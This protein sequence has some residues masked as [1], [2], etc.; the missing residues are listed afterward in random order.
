VSLRHFL[1]EPGEDYRVRVTERA[2]AALPV[3]V[4]LGA[5]LAAEGVGFVLVGSAA[6][7]LRGFEVTVGDVDI[8]ADLD[9]ANL[10][11]LCAAVGRSQPLSRR[12]PSPRSLLAVDVWSAQ[13]LYGRLDVMVERARHDLEVLRAGADAVLVRDVAVSVASARAAWELRRRFKPS[14]DHHGE[15]GG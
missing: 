15:V 13:T 1:S 2:S 5:M 14:E 9:A 7:W 3:P 8:V 10:Q 4:L 12:R 6:L 11:R